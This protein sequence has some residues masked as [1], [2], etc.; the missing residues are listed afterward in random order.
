[1]DKLQSLALPRS[2]IILQHLIIQ[3]SL[4]YLSSGPLQEVTN[5]ENFK[6]VAPIV[7]V[8]AYE[9]C[10]LTRGSK[11][12]DLTSKLLVFWKTGCEER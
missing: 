9:R 7:V 3:I 2:A 5:K 12:S 10:F 4:Y 1:M 11:Y 8:V 6:C